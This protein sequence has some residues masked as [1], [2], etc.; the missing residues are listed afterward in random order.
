MTREE[1]T[2]RLNRKDRGPWERQAGQAAGP[3]AGLGVGVVPGDGFDDWLPL[4]C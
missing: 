2:L 4:R 1:V 3:C